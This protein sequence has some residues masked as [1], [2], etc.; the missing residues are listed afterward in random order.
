M[1]NYD[2]MIL[3]NKILIWGIPT[4]LAI[5][6]HE[7]AH[8]FV[9]LRFGDQT[10]YILGRVTLNPLK[11]ID[12]IGTILIPGFLI[13]SGVP[14]IFGYAKPVPVNF[15]RLHPMRLGMIS[16]A[17]A[18]PLTNVFLAIFSVYLFY[19]LSYIPE[20][21][22]AD[23]VQMITHS[24]LINGILAIFNM[25]P[26]PPLDGG[27]VAVGILPEPFSSFLSRLEPYG[28]L[29][30]FLLISFPFL[31][32]TLFGVSISLLSVMIYPPLAFFLSLLEGIS[33]IPLSTLVN[34]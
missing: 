19:L 27:R 30:I 32:E 22:H 13:L 23:L 6:L 15:R 12:P 7:A 34:F 8:G 10:A 31:T 17:L 1:I 9:A 24:V 3:L 25:I 14:F 20:T 5:T 21:W 16:V 29:I 26:I 2:D 11:H 4:I 18:G 28:M 33:G